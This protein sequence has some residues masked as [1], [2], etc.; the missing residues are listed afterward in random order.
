MEPFP[1]QRLPFSSYLHLENHQT[2]CRCGACPPFRYLPDREPQ[3]GQ[4]HAVHTDESGAT[5]ELHIQPQW[6]SDVARLRGYST[7]KSSLAERSDCVMFSTPRRPRLISTHRTQ[8]HHAASQAAYWV[9]PPA[10][11]SMQRFGINIFI[12]H[13]RLHLKIESMMASCFYRNSGTPCWYPASRNVPPPADVHTA[14]LWLCY[15]VQSSSL[16][17]T[18]LKSVKILTQSGCRR[19]EQTIRLLYSSLPIQQPGFQPSCSMAQADDTCSYHTGFLLVLSR[20]H[21]RMLI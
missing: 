6:P 7:P 1:T 3:P 16:C 13:T 10:S 4:L 15:P 17:A 9:Q 2:T 20:R 12:L 19:R 5:P 21:E 18:S 14:T 11:S 8:D